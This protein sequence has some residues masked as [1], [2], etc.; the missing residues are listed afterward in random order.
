MEGPRWEH[1]STRLHAGTAAASGLGRGLRGQNQGA[2]WPPLAEPNPEGRFDEILSANLIPRVA[3]NRGLS[4]E[5]CWLAAKRGLLRFCL[6]KGR[7]AWAVTDS[8]RESAQ[9]RRVTGSLWPEIGRKAW[10]LPGSRGSWPLGTE[11]SRPF[12][13]VILVEGG[14]DLLAAHHLIV[15][16]RREDDTAAV[17][18]LG[19]SNRIPDDALPAFRG[20]RV[21][22]MAHTDSAG[23]KAGDSW[24]AQLKAAGATVDVAD[25]TPFRKPDGSPV[26]DLNDAVHV[27]PEDAHHLNDLIP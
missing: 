9:V 12:P 20:K 4:Q 24:R 26:K 13:T 23:T 15:E 8:K 11:E 25:F 3:S 1:A 5:G 19:A 7:L 6:W 18:I 22:I 14:P 21:R 10:T 17:A 16:H 2:A 27:R